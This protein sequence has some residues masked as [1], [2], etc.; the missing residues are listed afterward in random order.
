MQDSNLISLRWCFV[1]V[2]LLAA[3]VMPGCFRD[4]SSKHPAVLHFVDRAAGAGLDRILVSGGRHKLAIVENIGTGAGVFDADGDGLL[5]LFLSNAGS[6]ADG[7]VLP[8]PGPALYRQSSRGRF[9]EV[10]AELGIE[11]EGWGTGVAVG[12]YD[13]DGDQDLFLACWGPDRFWENRDGRFFEVSKRA[14]LDHEGLSTSAVFFDYDLDGLLDLYVAGY[15]QFDLEALPNDGEPCI[16]G[17][18]RV[19]CGPDFYEPA[20]D[21]LY[22]NE[23]GGRFRLVSGQA[24]IGAGVGGYGLGVAVDDFN[25]DGLPDLYVANDS[26]ENYLWMNAGAGKFTDEALQAGASLGPEGQGQAGMGVAIGD[27]DG[28]GLRDIFVTNYSQEQ[29]ALYR[30]AEGGGFIDSSSGCGFSGESYMALGWSTF[31]ADFDNDSDDD[32]FVANGHVHPAAAQVSSSLSYLQPCF[33]YLNDGEGR[34]ELC[35]ESIGQDALEARAHRGAAEGDI[36]GDGD[37]DILISVQG[38]PPVLLEN[39]TAGAGNSLLVEL[40]GSESNRE[41]I[42]ARLTGRVGGK[43]IT[44]RVGRGGGY[45]SASDARAH[46]GLGASSRLD[47]LEVWWPSG[48]KDTLAEMEAG[49]LYRIQESNGRAEVVRKLSRRP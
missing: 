31:F 47:S 16:E 26:T 39:R 6:L 5:D 1:L 30:G 27:Y 45:L 44:R 33:F 3:A 13:N 17:A 38:G 32:L 28:D 15:L 4:S 23:G 36:D 7:K 49:N 35:P 25:L 22:H 2:L 12:D 14:G 8:G 41:G 9:E 37:I 20:T 40:V 34:F 21:R 48:R 46:F 43:V 18:A 19:A 10:S 11:F 42:G 24:G 29:N